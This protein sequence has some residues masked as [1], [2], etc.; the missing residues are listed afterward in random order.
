M[1]VKKYA[2]ASGRVIDLDDFTPDSFTLDDIAHHLSKIQRYNGA[3]PIDVTYSVAEHSIN[4]YNHFLSEVDLDLKSILALTC[5][6]DVLQIFLLHDA[7][8]SMLTDIPSYL[9]HYLPDYKEVEKKVQRTIYKKYLGVSKDDSWITSYDKGIV[10]DE[11]RA[12]MPDRAH[13]Y[14]LYNKYPALGCEIKYNGKPS[15]VKAEFL[16]LCEEVGIHD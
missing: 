1:R 14:E 2:M 5:N 4:L 3:L 15:E 12:I 13:I 8:E 11:A 7:S 9:K 6:I 16:R 10:I